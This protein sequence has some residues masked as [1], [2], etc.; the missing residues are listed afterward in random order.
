LP[1]PS[2]ITSTVFR[3]RDE[4]ASIAAAWEQLRLSEPRPELQHHP[5]WLS[6]ELADA[7]A[8][9]RQGRV[10]ALFRDGELFAVA[11]ILLRRWVWDCR[12]AWRPLVR[13]PMR[14]AHVLGTSLLAP[15][16]LESQEMLIAAI[17]RAA[18]PYDV[19]LLEQVAVGSP[20]WET[21]ER[22]P[23]LRRRYYTRLPVGVT[24]R[25]VAELPGD[26]DSYLAGL[27]R[28]SRKRL[29]HNVR[30]LEKACQNGLRVARVTRPDELGAFLRQAEVVSQRTW[31]ARHL[32]HVVGA[33]G[34][35]ASRLTIAA[36]RGWLRSYLLMNGDEPLAFVVGFQSDGTFQYYRIGYDPKWASYSPGTSLLFRL[37]EDLFVHDPPT[38]VDFGHGDAAYKRIFG[39][40]THPEANVLLVRRSARGAFAC[41]ADTVISK[42]NGAGRRLV[43]RLGGLTALRQSLRSGR[44]GET[45]P[46]PPGANHR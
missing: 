7:P 23:L 40:H 8:D 17:D 39:T 22:S 9:G 12:I 15:P 2:S 16:D 30:S 18:D 24:P 20:L 21:L 35:A 11:P 31:Q 1:E 32:G 34:P 27:S 25:H 45:A 38:R 36:E 5:E 44:R 29:R 42:M 14:L 46:D 19:L 3:D 6:V 41:A 13:I 26:F 43:E 28:R 10:A 4:W 33:A 37:V